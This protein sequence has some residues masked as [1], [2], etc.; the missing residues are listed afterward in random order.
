MRKYLPNITSQNFGTLT[1][2]RETTKRSG[3]SIVWECTCSCGLETCPKIVFV[4]VGNLR[5]GN[6]KSCQRQRLMHPALRTYFN[7][8]RAMAKHRKLSFEL[9]FAQFHTIIKLPCYYCGSLTDVKQI[10][11]NSGKIWRLRANGIDRNDNS[12]GYIIE[13]CVPC[14][15]LCNFG[16]SNM[17]AQEYIDHCKKVAEFNDR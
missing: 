12:I 13:N 7:T 3:N 6:T 4:S 10:N 16:K 17:L 11:N 15:Q 5:H 9:T 8:T 1:A 14:C 2:I